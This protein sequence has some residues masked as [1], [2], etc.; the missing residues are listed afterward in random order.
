M[1]TPKSS[2]FSHRF[3]RGIK[4]KRTMKGSCIHPPTNPQEKDL[5]ITPIKSSKR[6]TGKN[7]YKP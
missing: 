2:P 7:S 6:K 5:E 1:K 3:G 4:G